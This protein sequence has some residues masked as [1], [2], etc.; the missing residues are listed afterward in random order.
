M[1]FNNLPNNYP[2]RGIGPIGRIL[3]ELEALTAQ[4]G[5]LLSLIASRDFETYRLLNIGDAGHHLDSDLVQ[6]DPEFDVW[7]DAFLNE[8]DR[9]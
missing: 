4:S 6:Y 3:K 1:G 9:R 5:D 2:V 7:L 8:F